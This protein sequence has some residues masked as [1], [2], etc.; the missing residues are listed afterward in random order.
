[1]I[2][3][4]T[5]QKSEYRDLSSKYFILISNKSA[6]LIKI[7]LTVITTP[8]ATQTGTSSLLKIMCWPT[9]LNTGRS[10]P[11]TNPHP[12]P[13]RPPPSSTAPNR[14]ARKIY[15]LPKPSAQTAKDC[16]LTMVSSLY[17]WF[18]VAVVYED[19]SWRQR[20][21]NTYFVVPTT[22]END[23]LTTIVLRE[24]RIISSLVGR[25]EALTLCTHCV[26]QACSLNLLTVSGLSFSARWQSPLLH[27]S[28][29][30]FFWGG[31]GGTGKGSGEGSLQP[32]EHVRLWAA[33]GKHT[34]FDFEFV[35]FVWRQRGAYC[36]KWG[37]TEST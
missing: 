15:F 2:S 10:K 6:H 7:C 27:I 28:F 19:R 31:G 23:G 36:L 37:E 26:Y 1:M 21:W 17:R 25:Q 5:F 9:A 32:S 12:T 3:G 16:P 18:T 20:F 14:R 8:H 22:V 13:T 11:T 29:F 33:L 35:S 30:F 4:I 34:A 24:A